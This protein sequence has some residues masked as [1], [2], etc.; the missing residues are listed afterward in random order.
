MATTEIKKYDVG[1]YGGGNNSK[2]YNY[3]AIIGLRRDDNSLIGAAYFHRDWSTLPDTDS[4][5]DS[6]YIYIHYLESDFPRILDL[7]RNEKPVY[8]R[9]VSGWDMASIDTYMEPVGEEERSRFHRLG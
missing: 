6:G 1:Y 2:N 4:M 3:K 8:V 5:S 9:Y 7:L